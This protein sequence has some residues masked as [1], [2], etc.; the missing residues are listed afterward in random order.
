MRDSWIK[1]DERADRCP[2]AC[3]VNVWAS[4][5]ISMKRD[6]AGTKRVAPARTTRLQHPAHCSP[7]QRDL[8]LLWRSLHAQPN[9]SCKRIQFHQMAR[10]DCSLF[11]FFYLLANN[12]QK[13][14]LVLLPNLSIRKTDVQVF[15]SYQVF[16]FLA[17][18]FQ[19]KNFNATLKLLRS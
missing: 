6:A 5:V 3:A 8:K 4:S 19:A 13:R 2:W 15:V 14:L 12:F 18:F 1:T 9:L 16:C 17:I 11:F 7:L 10:I